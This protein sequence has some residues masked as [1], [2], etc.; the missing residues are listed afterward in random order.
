MTIDLTR[1]NYIWVV[2]EVMAERTAS[3]AMLLKLIHGKT[4]DVVK[5]FIESLIDD[6]NQLRDFL[7]EDTYLVEGATEADLDLLF[8]DY[9]P[10]L[11]KNQIEYIEMLPDSPILTDD[12]LP[13]E[14]VAV[15]KRRIGFIQ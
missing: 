4:L 8:N 11:L 5:E 3:S 1:E 2:A 15:R 6:P 13:T 10:D 12:K 7:N 9:L 14:V